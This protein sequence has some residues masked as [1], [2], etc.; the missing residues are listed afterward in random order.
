[1][2]S[3]LE[4]MN[5]KVQ[6]EQN[7]DNV[8][9]DLIKEQKITLDM[10]IG[11]IIQKYPSVVEVLLSEGVQ[12]VG[13][14]V[15][16]WETLEQGLSGHGKTEEQINSILKAMNDSIVK[17]EIEGDDFSITEKALKEIKNNLKENQFLRIEVITGGC[18]GKSY[19]LSLDDVS[20]EGDCVEEIGGIK[21]VADKNSFELIKGSKLDYLDTFEE[22]GFRFVNPNAKKGCGCGKSFGV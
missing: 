19:S 22:K 20:K 1:M 18:S 14:H 4:E 13:C 6:E 9:T 7:E 10:T 2:E 17:D 11:D 3:N 5:Q 21:I 12:C 16:H 8:K 15:A